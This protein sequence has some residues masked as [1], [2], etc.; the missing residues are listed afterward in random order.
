MIEKLLKYQEVDEKLKAI[1]DSIKSSQEYQ[2]VLK[3]KKVIKAYNE[4]KD[5][6]DERSALL[7]ATYNEK[8]EFLTKLLD[9]AKEISLSLEDGSDEK[10]IA[11]LTKRV[12]EINKHLST[13]ENDIK[14]LEEDIKDLLQR[15]SKATR[16]AKAASE[17][18]AEYKVKYDELVK[19]KEG[20]KQAIVKEL[21][22]IAKEIPADIMKKYLDKR[23]DGKFKIVCP[24][25]NGYCTSCMTELVIGE[26][27][28]LKAEKIMEC[29]N[30]HKLIYL[31]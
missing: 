18:G 11:F 29:P 21:E 13:L 5:S 26:M 10:E 8:T 17:Q 28:K 31:G 6:Y 3:A 1:E 20:E 19:S 23:K 15:F 12:N 4:S 14:K 24:V 9:E 27:E 25:Q 16:S 2:M 7:M 30:C 22:G